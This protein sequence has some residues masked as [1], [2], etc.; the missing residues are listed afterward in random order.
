MPIV[1]LYKFHVF[2]TFA[3]IL[4]NN[5]IFHASDFDFWDLCLT[6]APILYLFEISTFSRCAFFKYFDIN[7]RI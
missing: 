4:Y 3:L 6:G 2:L 5:F 1:I 7:V